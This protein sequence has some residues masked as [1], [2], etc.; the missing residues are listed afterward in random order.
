M[1]DSK[2][3]FKVHVTPHAKQNKVIQD[4]DV[5]RVYTTTAPEKGHANGAVVELLAKHFGVA[6][7]KI[8]ISKGTTSRNKIVVIQ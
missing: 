8:V 5:L 1:N 2:K 4:N 3:I 7:S 6:K